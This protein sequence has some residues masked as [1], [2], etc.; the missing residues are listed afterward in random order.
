[1]TDILIRICVGA[2]GLTV[3]TVGIVGTADREVYGSL[4]L[5]CASLIALGLI[6]ILRALG[7]L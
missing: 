4:R 2:C 6:T 7:V 1:M 5:L 3:I